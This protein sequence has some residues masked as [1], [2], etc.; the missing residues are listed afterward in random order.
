MSDPLAAWNATVAPPP[1][2]PPM[3]SQRGHGIIEHVR[4]GVEIASTA[5]T[6]WRLGQAALPYV[7]AAALV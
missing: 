7:R 1:P 3:P 4:S 6:L 5:H 2:P